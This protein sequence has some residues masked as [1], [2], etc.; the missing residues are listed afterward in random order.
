MSVYTIAQVPGLGMGYPA[1]VS[2]MP[3][4]FNKVKK[5]FSLHSVSY[6]H[7]TASTS[8]SAVLHLLSN[9]DGVQTCCT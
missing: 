9:L 8:F 5:C 7:C 6:P 4:G 3:Q 2:F 1:A